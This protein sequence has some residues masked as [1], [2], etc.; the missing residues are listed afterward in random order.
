MR[1]YALIIWIILFL[2]ILWFLFVQPAEEEKPPEGKVQVKM[3]IWGGVAETE[4]WAAREKDFESKNPDIDVKIE[5]VPA[6]YE[7]KMLAMLAAGTAPDII[8]LNLADF[9]SKD[10][11]LPLDPFLEKDSTF[12][13]DAFLPGMWELGEWRG[14]RLTVP[15]GITTQVLFYKKAHFAEAGL[16]TPNEYAERG[17]W[18]W[19]TFRKVCKK[20]VKKN[21]DGRIQRYAYVHYPPLWTY[22]YMFGGEPFKNDYTECNFEDP[23]VYGAYQAV[24]DLALVDSVAPPI[25]VTTQVGSA[26]QAF[27]HDRSSMLIS[28]PWM[29]R[30]FASIAGTYDIAPPPMEPGGKAMQIIG[31]R[32]G[33]IWR[34]SKNPEAAYKWFA[35]QISEDGMRIWSR[36]GFDLPALKSLAAHP[37]AWM[38]TTIVPEHFHLFY[39]LLDESVKPPAAIT[40]PIPAKL[41]QQI[42]GTVWDE[43]RRG[44][45][46]A[47]QAFEDFLPKAQKIMKRGF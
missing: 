21:K 35:Y 19:E 7:Y 15:A 14:Q 44:K 42:D 4:A 29:V 45:K 9:A 22:V 20:L 2:A 25:E 46:T 27:L 18:N 38:D 10:V 28:G 31:N 32:I 8:T 37:E 13:K 30:R 39:D 24:A 23:K 40:P 36:L 1:N 11:F 26:W 43:I 33:G 5:L 16:P 41:Q 6:N 17:E 12:D 47:K 3:A 34:G